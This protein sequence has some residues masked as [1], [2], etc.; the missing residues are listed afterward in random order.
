MTIF[1]FFKLLKGLSNNPFKLSSDY[2]HLNYLLTNKY[3]KSV[4]KL[5][6]TSITGTRPSG[7][8]TLTAEGKSAMFTFL[9]Q[10]IT[11]GISLTAIIISIIALCK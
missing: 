7:K 8:Y 5:S 9:N 1:M 3:I 4:P 6:E 2:I 10:T 11:W